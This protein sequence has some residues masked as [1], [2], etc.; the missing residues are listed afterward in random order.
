MKRYKLMTRQ[1]WQKAQADEALRQ[2]DSNRQPFAIKTL[3]DNRSISQYQ[4]V[5][6]FYDDE[7][8]EIIHYCVN[9]VEQVCRSI[10]HTGKTGSISWP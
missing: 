8:D 1:A 9:H 2:S 4:R 10:Y 6:H 7:Y 3:L 5:K